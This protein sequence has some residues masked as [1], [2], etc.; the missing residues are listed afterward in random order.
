MVCLL[1]LLCSLRC[2]SVLPLGDISYVATPPEEVVIVF[3]FK[4][5]YINKS[6]LYLGFVISSM[7]HTPGVR[8]QRFNEKCQ[9]PPSNVDATELDVV[10]EYLE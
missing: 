4:G 6:F 5:C 1:A 2:G 3:F 10:T 7:G 8:L 9:A